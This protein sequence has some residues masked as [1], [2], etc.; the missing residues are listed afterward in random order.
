MSI[1]ILKQEHIIFVFIM[2]LAYTAHQ[3]LYMNYWKTEDAKDME[4]ESKRI[5]ANYSELIKDK[6]VLNNHIFSVHK[7]PKQLKYIHM[8]K[9]LKER[10]EDLKFV[11]KYEPNLLLDII[12]YMEHFLKIHF[13]VMINKYD[14]DLYLPLLYDIK[15]V[16][17]RFMIW[18]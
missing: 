1:I 5:W 15:D 4:K 10:L 12:I 16:V 14:L 11:S 18:V 6:Q 8:H 9:D 2:C 13:N 17:R 3:K 7:A